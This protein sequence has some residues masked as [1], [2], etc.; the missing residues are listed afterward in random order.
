MS[1]FSQRSQLNNQDADNL[2]KARCLLNLQIVAIFHADKER[3]TIELDAEHLHCFLR[4]IEELISIEDTSNFSQRSQLNNEDADNLHK[5][6]CLL[7]LQIA[8]IFHADK[9]RKTI[10]LDAEHLHCFLRHIEELISIEGV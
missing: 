10:E 8:T 2:H 6:R 1:N 7:N 9:E 4:H 5:A 3:K